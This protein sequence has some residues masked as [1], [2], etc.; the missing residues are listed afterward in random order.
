MSSCLWLVVGAVVWMW[1]E[2]MGWH[3]VPRVVM[4]RGDRNPRIQGLAEVL[5]LDRI[6]AVPA[7]LQSVPM[8]GEGDGVLSGLRHTVLPHD[9]FR[10]HVH[11]CDVTCHEAACT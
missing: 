6:K 2:F 11:P 5:C 8:A 10:V 4:L 7:G 1:P 3:L 9:L